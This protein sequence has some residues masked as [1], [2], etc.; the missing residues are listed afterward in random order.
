MKAMQKT[1]V[2]SATYRQASKTTPELQQRDPEN[3]LLAR[4]PRFRLPAEMV[5]DQALA[6]S[7]LAGGKDRRP[8]GEALSAGRAVE[9][10]SRVARITSRD[11]GEGLYRRSLY[12]YLEAHRAAAH[13]DELRRRR[14]RSLRGARTRTNTP[15][16]ALDLMNDVTYPRSV[17][18]DG[19]ADDEGGRRDTG[20]APRV[21]IRTG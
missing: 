13:D 21:W 1:I 11:N 9:G 6:V 5:R 12:T 14:A 18:Q 4:G 19:G 3:R 7:G 8:V 17:A 15:L 20:A 10:S 2:M 16:Q